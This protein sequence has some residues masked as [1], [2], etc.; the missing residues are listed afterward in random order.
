MYNADD[1]QEWLSKPTAAIQTLKGNPTAAIQLKCL[2]CTCGDTQ[3]IKS[4][5]AYECPLW[6]FRPYRNKESEQRPEG[7]FPTLERLHNI[8]DKVPEFQPP[9]I[10]KPRRSRRTKAQMQAYRASLAAKESKT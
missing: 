10:D 3:L 7:T 5:S 2:Q 4:C 1:F 6:Q 9:R 8:R